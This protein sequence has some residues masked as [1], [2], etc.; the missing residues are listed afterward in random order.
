MVEVGGPC[1]GNGRRPAGQQHLAC[2]AKQD[3][4]SAGDAAID[5]DPLESM[6]QAAKQ[7]GNSSGDAASYGD[8]LVLESMPEAVKQNA[9]STG[10][11]AEYGDPLEDVLE[12][13][14]QDENFTS[15]A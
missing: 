14:R 7:D 9:I 8:P 3:G 4:N 10:D 15:Y 12:T 1:T 13:V 2:D 5:G 6:P 11:A